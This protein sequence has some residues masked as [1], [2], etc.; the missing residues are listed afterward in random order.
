[1][2]QLGTNG[3]PFRKLAG[4]HAKQWNTTVVQFLHNLVRRGVELVRQDQY[5]PRGTH[6]SV[7]PVVSV[8]VVPAVA[9]RVRQRVRRAI[10]VPRQGHP[11]PTVPDKSDLANIVIP[12]LRRVESDARRGRNG[13]RESEWADA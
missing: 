8:R 11:I 3:E 12:Q 4:I 10:R 6:R 1:M 13:Q 9:V 7:L 2:G 5:G